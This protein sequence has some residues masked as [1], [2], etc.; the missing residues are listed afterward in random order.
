MVI[1]YQVGGDVS[2]TTATTAASEPGRRALVRAADGG[3]HSHVAGYH[4]PPRPRLRAGVR[5]AARAVS[6][7]V[8]AVMA[9]RGGG[10]RSRCRPRF[11]AAA[12]AFAIE[13][14]DGRDVSEVVVRPAAR[15]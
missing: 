8:A 14:A 1:E 3:V 13:Q 6:P 9:R 10:R 7:E 5:R 2:S 4:A 15:D 12:I 11:V